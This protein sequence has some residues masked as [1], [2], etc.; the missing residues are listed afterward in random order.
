MK[1]TWNQ[2]W[3]S[4]RIQLCTSRE[5]DANKKRLC[6]IRLASPAV[7]HSSYASY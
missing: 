4:K 7:L 3:I 6:S 5:K 2:M 1:P